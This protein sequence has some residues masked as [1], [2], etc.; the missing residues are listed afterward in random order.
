[1]RDGVWFV[2][3]AALKD[4]AMVPVAVAAVVGMKTHSPAVLDALCDHLRDRDLLLVFDNC[5]HLIESVA[6]C[7]DRILSVAGGVRILA[8]SREPLAVRGEKLRRLRG[9]KAPPLSTDLR[10]AKALTYPAIQLFVERATE[11]LEWF[12]LR[13]EDTPMAVEICRRLDGLALAIELAATRIDAFSVGDLL[14]QLDGRF[15]ALAGR[16]AGPA[17]QRTLAATLDWSCNLLPAEEAHLLD[18]CAV[19]AGA[20]GVDDAAAVAGIA[21]EH[22]AERLAQLAAKSLLATDLDRE[23]VAYRLLETTSAFCRHRLQAVER[24]DSV[25]RR[26]AEHIVAV[27]DR[28]LREWADLSAR[29]WGARYGPV[30]RDLRTAMAWAGTADRLLLIELTVRGTVLW[31]HFSLTNECR[32]AVLRAVSELAAAGLTGTATEMKLQT[33]L[34]GALMFTRGPTHEMLEASRRAL[35]IAVALEDAELHLLNLW[36]IAGY[37]VFTGQYL[38]ATNR[39]DT[40]LAVARER[41]PTALQDGESSLALA[42]FSLGR[43]DSALQRVEPHFRHDPPSL[44]DARLARF[45]I[46]TNAK[47]GMVLAMTQWVMGWPDKAAQTADA[48]VRLSLQTG[49]EM[50]VIPALVLAGCPVA[51]CRGCHEGALR[52]IL[53]L[54][55]LLDQHGLETWRPVALYFRGALTCAEDRR[56]VEGIDMLRRAILGLDTMNQRQ[57]TPYFLGTL[58]EALFRSSRAAE[59]TT[60]IEA[61]L[62]RARSQNEKWCLPELLR[63]RASILVAEGHLRDAEAELL[64]SMAVAEEI[65]ALSWKLRAANDLASLWRAEFRAE[66]A[67][68]LLL[69]VYRQITEGHDTCDLRHAARLLEL[70]GAVSGGG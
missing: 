59:A 29:E 10:A 40:F 61:A 12:E 7:S 24:I 53:M 55:E 22:A 23:S 26:H 62:D 41:D 65:G 20:F 14:K 66:A 38:A 49:H 45:Q 11:R 57:R 68:E 35:E 69:P 52:N 5:E 32:V 15:P 1:M 28:S 9:L 13:D 70:H 16:R 31:N 6:E 2:D 46:D 19:F 8:T 56:L 17:R 54:E 44:A 60:T 33:F 48:V 43:L 18:A 47:Y 50:T 67:H 4:P 36:L 27:L 21:P 42:E 3:F 63:I 25:H 37:E 30:L 64:G 39:L 58:A 51:L 34:A